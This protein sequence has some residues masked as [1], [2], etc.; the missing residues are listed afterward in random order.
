MLYAY[1]LIDVNTFASGQKL[2]SSGINTLA[3]ASGM[4]VAGT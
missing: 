2:T 4:R 3:V 1:Y